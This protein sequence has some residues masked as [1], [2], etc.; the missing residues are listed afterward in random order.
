MFS[1]VQSWAFSQS[2]QFKTA[3]F[4]ICF[5]DPQKPRLTF[6]FRVHYSGSS[7]FFVLLLLLFVLIPA[8]Q[9]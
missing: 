9:A 4:F 5:I 6:I 1:A 7:G 3:L 2:G 8:D